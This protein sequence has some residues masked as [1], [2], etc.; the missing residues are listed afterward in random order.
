MLYRAGN[1]VVLCTASIDPG[2]PTWLAGKGKGGEQPGK[3]LR[4]LKR[5]R[6]NART[7]TQLHGDDRGAAA[8]C[9]CDFWQ[10]GA[11]VEMYQQ[12]QLRFSLQFGGDK[13]RAKFELFAPA[14]RCFLRQSR[15]RPRV[16]D[17]RRRVL[18]LLRKRRCTVA[19]QPTHNRQKNERRQNRWTCLDHISGLSS[20]CLAV[21][22]M[23]R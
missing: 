12:R 13:K 11:A 9:R 7:C 14:G 16:F 22:K 19:Q 23:A 5:A 18:R 4:V 8:F 17:H 3:Q 6:I 2:V 21:K 15:M 20:G 1:T 10:P